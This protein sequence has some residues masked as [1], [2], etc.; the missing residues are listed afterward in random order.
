VEVEGHVV[1]LEHDVA[2]Q[3][4]GAE[5]GTESKSRAKKKKTDEACTIP[6][7]ATRTNSTHHAWP[8]DEPCRTDA[9]ATA[10][11]SRDGINSS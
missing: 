3:S 1:H 7:P 2:R 9:M 5:P 10:P 4:G 6:H 8:L 11:A